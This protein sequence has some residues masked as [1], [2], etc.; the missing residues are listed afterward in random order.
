[1]IDHG[2]FRATQMPQFFFAHRIELSA[3]KFDATAYNFAVYT[4]V[5]HHP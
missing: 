2:D 1:M 3:L 5:L 4:K